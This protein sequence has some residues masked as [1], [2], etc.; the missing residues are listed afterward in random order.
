MTEFLHYL[1][2]PYL[3]DGILFTLRLTA[4]GFVG[5][6]ILG[7][8]LAAMQLTRFRALTW[9][10]RAYVTL[11]RGTPLILQLVEKRRRVL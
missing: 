7:L 2:L 4:M 1:T 11:Y 10:A 5:G 3:L 8:F 9:V 6:M